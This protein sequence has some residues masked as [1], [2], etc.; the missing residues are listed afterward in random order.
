MYLKKL[1]FSYK[2]DRMEDAYDPLN[3]RLS[4]FLLFEET[5]LQ[6]SLKNII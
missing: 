6:R 4:L 5:K 1:F 3:L 2:Y